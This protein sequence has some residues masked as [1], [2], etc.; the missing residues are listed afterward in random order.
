MSRP[1]HVRSV[2]TMS[3]QKSPAVRKYEL[4]ARAASQRD[5]GSALA[6]FGY[7]L[8][9][10]PLG[11]G[12]IGLV[13]GVVARVMPQTAAVPSGRRDAVIG[14][15]AGLGAMLLCCAIGVMAGTFNNVER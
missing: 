7:I 2:N 5:T 15:A 14:I 12:L 4:K 10:L 8:A 6:G 13:L 3:S 1:E 11:G 9:F